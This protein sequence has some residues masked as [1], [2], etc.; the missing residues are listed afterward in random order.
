MNIDEFGASIKLEK[1]TVPQVNAMLIAQEASRNA[2][3]EEA[4]AMSDIIAKFPISVGDEKPTIEKIHFSGDVTVVIWSDKTKTLVRRQ[5]DEF[6]DREKAVLA[7]IAKKFLG[8]NKSKSNWLDKIKPAYEKAEEE[9]EREFEIPP[10][11]TMS[12]IFKDF[13]ESVN[14]VL[15]QIPDKINKSNK[16]NDKNDQ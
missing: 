10:T 2:L 6:D 8:T 16:E 7:C 1:D 11:A 3:L 4:K 5:N 9:R 15:S 12:E 13:V 14:S